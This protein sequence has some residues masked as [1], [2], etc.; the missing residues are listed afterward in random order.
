M[1]NELGVTAVTRTIRQ[2]LTDGVAPKWG[3][4]VPGGDLLK[5]L[6]I[7]TLPPHLVRKKHVSEN[8][9]NIYLYRTDLNGAWRNQPLPAAGKGS[10]ANPPLALNLD[11]L[12]TAWGEDDQEE[13][14]HFFLGQ[15]M[16]VLHDT[17]LMPRQTLFDVLKKA[18][19][20]DQI[21]RITIT[22]KTLNLEEMMNLWSVF[23]SEY[24]VSAAYLITV[25][26]I[27]SKV[28]PRSALPVLMRGP[29]DSG[30]DALAAAAPVID[31]ARAATGFGAVRLGEELVIAG[32]RL[33][34]AGLTARLRHPFMPAAVELPVLP[35]SAT[36]A[37]VQLP[38]AAAGSGVAAA[39]P[40]GVYSL[41]L[42]VVRPG[43]PT[44]TTNEVPFALA[45]SITATPATQQPPA[46]FELTI[47]AIPQIHPSQSAFVLWDDVQLTPKSVT[48]VPGDPDAATEVKADVDVVIAPVAVHRVRLRVDGIDS[49]PIV[50][51]GAIY[52]FDDA[53][54]VEVKP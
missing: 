41:S 40:A 20:H 27:E 23:Q 15:A 19:V 3:T 29:N 28:P 50:Q 16:R 26:L 21:D 36:E 4:D 6:F 22:P 32:Q 5:Q 52:K 8:V 47:E 34:T 2:L 31:S 54:S 39:W 25:V 45:P 13:V 10:S 18:H 9:I 53:Q 11:Y 24:R 37:R 49:I 17:A 1:S 38:A 43:K 46:T 35:V 51:S 7:E 48:N 30:I 44:W 12:I 33:D 14:A 42:A